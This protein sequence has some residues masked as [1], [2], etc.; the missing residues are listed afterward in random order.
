MAPAISDGLAAGCALKSGVAQATTA[1]AAP[2]LRTCLWQVLLSFIPA[3][4]RN[5]VG[6]NLFQEKT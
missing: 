2:Y 4:G 1:G 5:T 6:H 3:H